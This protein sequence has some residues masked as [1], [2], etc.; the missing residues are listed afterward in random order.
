MF[1]DN[2]NTAKVFIPHPMKLS[3]NSFRNRVFL[4]R[5][6]AFFCISAIQSS[7]SLTASRNP[8]T[9]SISTRALLI[10][11]VMVNL[12]LNGIFGLSTIPFQN[13]GNYIFNPP[14]SLLP[15]KPHGF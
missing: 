9:R 14:L 7:L 10:F 8:R 3:D 13:H 1:D 6:S 15:Q 2:Y 4:S 5:I 12:G 11:G